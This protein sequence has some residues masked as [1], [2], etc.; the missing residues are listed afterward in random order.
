MGK[1]ISIV[2]LVFGFLTVLEAARVVERKLNT[3]L[4]T[5]EQ[6]HVVRK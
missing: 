6:V 5:L 2:L 3:D 1:L 4:D